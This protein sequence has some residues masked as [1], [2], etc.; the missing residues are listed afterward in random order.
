MSEEKK[1]KH[2]GHGYHE[3]V[4]R[5]FDDGSAAIHHKVHPDH[6]HEMKDKEYGVGHLD[7]IHDGIEDH[8][9]NPE[10]IEAKLQK[11]GIDP[12]KL[13]EAIKPGLHERMAELTK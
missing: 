3:T 1:I 9:R 7:E 12:E 10:E 8:L 5:H 4:I 11:Q 6:V 13:E 2:A